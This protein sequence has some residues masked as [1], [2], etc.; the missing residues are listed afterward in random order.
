MQ[1]QG[2]GSASVTRKASPKSWPECVGGKRQLAKQSQRRCPHVATGRGTKMGGG[3]GTARRKGLC[4]KK[5]LEGFFLVRNV[6]LEALSSVLFSEVTLGT[7]AKDLESG[8]S[9]GMA[10]QPPTGAQGSQS[11]CGSPPSAPR[12]T[13]PGQ[14]CWLSARSRGRH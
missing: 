10:G 5:G 9:L 2:A 13:K 12:P 6:H 3:G 4:C 1:D 14:R 8:T 7:G 11:S